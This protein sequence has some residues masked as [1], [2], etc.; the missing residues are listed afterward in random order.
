MGENVGYEINGK[1]AL[2]SRPV[3]ILKKLSSTV[4]I[5]IPLS[6]K[7]KEGSWF[8]KIVHKGKSEVANI[9]QLRLLDFRRLSNK[10]GELNKKDFKEI[11][12]RLAAL[13]GL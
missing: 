8:V 12:K 11:K 7:K 13:L 5:G 3:V 10:Q 2:F 6:S 9:S 4:F 1:S